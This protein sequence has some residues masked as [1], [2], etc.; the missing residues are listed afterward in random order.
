MNL[1]V[2][3]YPYLVQEYKKLGHHVTTAGHYSNCDLLLSEFSYREISSRLN[4][5]EFDAVIYADGLDEHFLYTEIVKFSCP[6][7][8][9]GIDST[10]NFFWQKH[11]S[12]L[13]DLIFF[14]Q[15]AE[16]RAM[17][18]ERAGCFSLLLGFDN[19]VYKDYGLKKDY[20]ITFVGR[21][22]DNTRPKRN[23]LLNLLKSNHFNL[24]IVDGI[25]NRV[26]SL[27]LAKIYNSSRIVVNENMFPGIN[28]RL[29]EALG[30]NTLV[31]TE[32]SCP[33]L[34][35]F[36]TDGQDLVTYNAQNIVEKLSFYLNNPPKAAKIALKGYQKAQQWHT[37][38]KRA[39]FVIARIMEINRNQN[40]RLSEQVYLAKAASY[41][42]LKWPQAVSSANNQSILEKFYSESANA[43]EV[44]CLITRLQIAVLGNDLPTA[45]QIISTINIENTDDIDLLQTVFWA[46]FQC[47]MI[48]VYQNIFDLYLSS[49][50]AKPYTKLSTTDFSRVD[51]Y[52]IIW[53]DFLDKKGKKINFGLTA[54]LPDIF[55]S[56][57]DFYSKCSSSEVFAE[58]ALNKMAEILIDGQAFD[59]AAKI[60]DKLAIMLPSNYLYH[61]KSLVCHKK[62]YRE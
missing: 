40:Y 39:E 6:T 56:A 46:A 7:V 18:L 12:K 34:S 42:L 33:D 31:F 47:K 60:Y 17:Q 35:Q 52:R 28:L 38:Q 1:L 10:I 53:A 5:S 49:E 8:Y 32:D 29:F 48:K 51:F 24:K 19:S 30:C 22:N 14:D 26:N 25:N 54:Q 21:L 9:I 27:E 3:N 2:L 58:Q 11:Y 59:F 55:C 50:F 15:A 57:F 36:F 61:E 23:N 43:C 45:K 4:M 62:S 41:C 20:D 16:V 13:F 44:D 37:D